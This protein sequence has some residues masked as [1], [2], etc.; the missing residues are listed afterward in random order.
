ML[1]LHRQ[2]EIENLLPL[3]A[4]N[5]VMEEQLPGTPLEPWSSFYLLPVRPGKEAHWIPNRLSWNNGLNVS[6][7]LFPCYCLLRISTVE[8]QGLYFFPLLLQTSSGSSLPPKLNP[9]S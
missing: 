6:F 7:D 4:D 8:S 1:E 9:S 2:M 5:I 3:K